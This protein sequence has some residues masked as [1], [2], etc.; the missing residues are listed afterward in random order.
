MLAFIWAVY[1]RKVNVFTRIKWPQI[2]FPLAVGALSTIIVFEFD[3]PDITKNIDPKND[4]L[5][6]FIRFTYAIALME[7][8]CK[9]IGFLLI[10][11]IWLA[12]AGLLKKRSLIEEPNIIIYASLVALGF[13]TVEN[14]IYMEKSGI[15]VVYWRGIMSTVSHIVGSSIVAGFLVVG[16]RKSVIRAILYSLIGLVIATLMHGLYDFFLSFGIP[17][18]FYITLIIFSIQIEVWARILNNFLN[19]SRRIYLNKCLDRN[20]MQRFLL[21]AFLAAGVVQ[22][23]GLIYEEGLVTGIKSHLNILFQEL[24]ITIIL[25]VRI[26]RFTVIP[27][28]WQRILPALPVTIRRGKFQ[29]SIIPTSPRFFLK[30]KGDEFNEYPFTSRIEQEVRL[31]A[32]PKGMDFDMEVNVK[33]ITKKF[34]GPKKELYYLCE[35]MDFHTIHP[36]YNSRYVLIRPKNYGTKFYKRNA[37]VGLIALKGFV[38]LDDIYPKDCKFMGW[39]MMKRESEKSI[40]KRMLEIL[41]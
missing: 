30:I 32:L 22:L 10:V 5:L 18:F 14:Y 23:L 9:F 11:T 29:R 16:Y 8:L 38:N 15:D 24:I 13:A 27:R 40:G 33:M 6:R 4:V 26:T 17:F 25:I 41:R 34:I 7:E 37:I 20:T 2:L 3:L 36:Q 12:L 21:I 19:F 31:R 39:M 35:V 1:L 28:Y